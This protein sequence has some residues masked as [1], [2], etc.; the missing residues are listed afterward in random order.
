MCQV[1]IPALI[2]LQAHCNAR[3]SLQLPHWSLWKWSLIF[4]SFSFF[5]PLV[6]WQ[7]NAYLNHLYTLNF[8]TQGP[9]PLISTS[10]WSNWTHPCH[11]V[12]PLQCCICAF[13]VALSC[14]S[15]THKSCCLVA[16]CSRLTWHL[17]LERTDAPCASLCICIETC[18]Q[19]NYIWSHI[20]ELYPCEMN[21]ATRRENRFSHF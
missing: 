21:N 1:L 11:T 4:F 2:T 7:E 12:E 10:N 5:A 9:L 15:Q 3:L 6:K 16:M 18:T 17:Y 14:W 19:W 20:W 13:E 8:C